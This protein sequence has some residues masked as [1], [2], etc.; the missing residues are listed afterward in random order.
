V[1]GQQIGL[2][3]LMILG[4]LVVARWRL[5]LRM[6][7]IGFRSV[8]WIWTAVVVIGVI[9]IVMWGFT[10]S[11]EGRNE[12]ASQRAIGVTGFS[13]LSL[14]GVILTALLAPARALLQWSVLARCMQPAC[15]FGMLVMAASV[16]LHLAEERYWTLRDDLSKT[17]ASGWAHYELD[18]A[19]S[20]QRD[21]LEILDAV[22]PERR[23]ALDLAPAPK[24]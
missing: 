22:D 10:F 19:K 21:L 9:S 16:P 6:G 18:V 13:V 4:P 24:E 3:V 2:L 8:W 20:I 5:S 23:G 15:V 17:H 11:E 14:V 12:S 7:R 1:I